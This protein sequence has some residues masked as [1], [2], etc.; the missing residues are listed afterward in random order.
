MVQPDALWGK[1]QTLSDTMDT[2]RALSPHGDHRRGGDHLG[3]PHSDHESMVRKLWKSDELIKQL[4]HI[5]KAQHGKIEELRERLDSEPLGMVKMHMANQAAENLSK[6]KE[7]NDDQRRKLQRV[8]GELEKVKSDND[9]LRK[10]NNRLKRMMEQQR[11]DLYLPQVPS[12]PQFGESGQHARGARFGDRD[13]E[14]DKPSMIRWGDSEDYGDDDGGGPYSARNAGMQDTLRTTQ[15]L[16]NTARSSDFAATK[17]SFAA[18]ENTSGGT[19]VSKLWRLSSV[20]PMFWRDLKNG[21]S[22]VLS[23]LVE[24]AVR[25][26]DGG[27][28]AS[29]TIYMLDD[30]LRTK[31]V[32]PNDTQP[33]ALF[34][35]GAGK[36]TAQVFRSDSARAEPPKYQDLKALPIRSRNSLALAI[37][38]PSSHK[39]MAMLQILATEESKESKVPVRAPKALQE[40][41]G[42][43]QSPDHNGFTETHLMHLQMVCTVAGGILEQLKD[44]DAKS[45]LLE[46]MRSCF[47]VSVAVNQARSLPDFE[48]RVKTLLGNFFGVNTVRVLFYD[49]DSN[50]LLIS[51]AQM[52]RKGLLRLGLDKGVV[53]VCAKRQQVIHV[54]NI[55]HHPYI[56]A[57]ADGLQRA[58]RPV[59]SEASMLIGPLVIE[60]VEG[61]RLIGVVQLLERRKDKKDSGP[62]K[63]EEFS[64]EEQSL[65]NQLLRVC[66]QVAW[67]TY[68]VQELTA[69]VNNAP[70][71]LADMLAG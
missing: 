56:D 20:L 4:K 19:A 24:M 62:T 71:S 69:Q 8:N 70:M 57:A 22:S 18:T 48:Q 32:N 36:T 41:L 54:A 3:A 23:T 37:M 46:R 30:W 7:D 63:D 59:S 21:P 9:T 43:R 29:I 35:L 58:G 6:V 45:Y 61:A 50:E 16:L 5:V 52:R 31:A 53:G 11:E 49:A 27:P 34:F 64:A 55:S 26:L 47:D 39:K 60:N 65:F 13:G 51:S 2:R 67:R 10:A 68:K 14:S 12:A 28:S 1:A 33:P 44:A 25:L 42:G 38:M 17:K 15:S 40:R 66:A